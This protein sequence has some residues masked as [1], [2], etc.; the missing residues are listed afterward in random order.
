VVGSEK[1]NLLSVIMSV[2][3]TTLF[4]YRSHDLQHADKYAVSADAIWIPIDIAGWSTIPRET[5]RL[6]L[7]KYWTKPGE[8]KKIQ[9]AAAK[10]EKNWLLSV[11]NLPSFKEMNWA[12]VDRESMYW[13]WRDIAQ[14]QALCELWNSLDITRIEILPPTSSSNVPM[15]YYGDSEIAKL[16]I[17]HFC[18]DKLAFTPLRP[19]PTPLSAPL[20]P[21]RNSRT[22][23]RKIANLA[24]Q[25]RKMLRGK[26]FSAQHILWK[27]LNQLVKPRTKLS[28]STFPE[29]AQSLIE[30]P[31][32]ELRIDS[33]SVIFFL[34][35][36]EA[37]RFES[38][39][40]SLKLAYKENLV[41]W[42]LSGTGR[43]AE[44]LATELEIPVIPP[45]ISP[46]PT[47]ETLTSF[48]NS[49]QLFKATITDP[50]KEMVD[51]ISQQFEFLFLKRYPG[52]EA[53]LAFWR[54]FWQKRPPKI[55]IGSG[56]EDA[57]TQIPIIAASQLQIT[58]I[59]V[60]HGAVYTRSTNLMAEYALYENDFSRNAFCTET[61][62]TKLIPC[63]GLLKSNEYPTSPE[64]RPQEKKPLFSILVLLNSLGPITS[65]APYVSLTGHL[66]TLENISSIP[67]ELN[68]KVEIKFR[69]HPCPIFGGANILRSCINEKQ[70]L[71][72]DVDL[73]I[74]IRSFD[75]FVLFNGFGSVV[76]PLLKH[77]CPILLLWPDEKIGEIGP[78]ENG[79]DLASLG[80][81]I[82]NSDDF[83]HGIRNL[84]AHP[85]QL[86]E[87]ANRSITLCQKKLNGEQHPQLSSILGKI[88]G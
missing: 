26:H 36:L 4:A 59:A 45:P 81:P 9:L 73:E 48:H 51:S 86:P 57:E 20:E 83:W 85:S 34:H 10:H 14:A 16:V 19:P 78:F 12:A 29:E 42:L 23:L 7:N 47:Q 40:E 50:F 67:S 88:S 79:C 28:I 58:T 6:L 18:A 22:F 25:P 27:I 55:V 21:S 39:I 49:L 68:E 84:L 17:M 37:D 2:D 76:S 69:P 24:V 38:I 54:E 66:E 71:G 61:S 46:D 70:L 56:L 1:E 8:E 65:I 43:D 63:T 74:A 35:P 3:P 75:L 31:T 80:P 33:N 87:L 44:I 15:Q 72:C 30:R 82:R 41:L 52:L 60:P 62:K 53:S 13:F 77:S 64:A 32:P 5:R 11:A